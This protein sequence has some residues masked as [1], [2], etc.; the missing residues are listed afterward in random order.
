MKILVQLCLKIADHR[1]GCLMV[2]RPI[3]REANTALLSTTRRT[4]HNR[5]RTAAATLWVPSQATVAIQ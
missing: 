3:Q 2:G 5:L 1:S 4:P